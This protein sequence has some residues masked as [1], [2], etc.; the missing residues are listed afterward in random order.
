MVEY[1]AVQ[2]VSE[3]I[4]TDELE[5]VRWAYF[6][7]FIFCLVNKYTINQSDNDIK[8]A[9]STPT[10]CLATKRAA[11]RHQAQRSAAESTRFG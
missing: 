4:M 10:C 8:T 11:E 3:L 5:L 1:S 7:L 6:Q 9:P 2:T